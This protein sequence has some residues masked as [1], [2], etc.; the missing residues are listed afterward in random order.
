MTELKFGRYE[1][2]AEIGQGAM[3]KVY[4][5]LDP[6]TDR[7]VAIKTLKDDIVA[8]DKTG[9]YV[10]RFQREARAAGGLSHPNIIKVY[11]VGENYYVMEYL[12]GK[13]LLTLL[14]EKGTFMLDETLSIVAPIA[15]ALA[16]AHERGVYHRDIKPANIMVFPDG[17][18]IITDFGLAHLE[19]SVMTTAGQFLGSPSYMSP[20][21]VIGNELT[22][23]ADLYSLA[24]VTYEM[25]TGDKPFPG[26]NITTVVYKIV[27][28]PPV[29][30]HELN[31]R[32]PSEYEHIFAKALAKEPEQRFADF[33][34]FVSALNLEQFDR[35][36]LGVTEDEPTLVQLDEDQETVELPI[37]AAESRS[38]VT[39]RKPKRRALMMMSQQQKLI[40]AGAAVVLAAFIGLSVLFAPDPLAEGVVIETDPVEAN[41]FLDGE[42]LGISPIELPP[43]AF[44]EHDVRVEKEG[45]LPFEERFELIAGNAI[46]P[47]V[48]ALQSARISL[49]LESVPAGA[50]VTID[51]ESSGQTPLEDV[52]LEPGQ[53]EIQVSRRGYNSWRRVL[54]ARAGESVNLVARLRAR[55]V[56]TAK[57]ASAASS[58]PAASVE[59]AAPA[60]PA[61]PARIVELGPDDTPAKH[62]S[63]KAP[64]YPPMARKL[65]QQGRVTIEFVLTEEG[66]PTELVVVESAGAIL[67]KA[68]LDALA[69][70]RYEPAM[71]NNEPVRVKMRVRQRFRLG[72]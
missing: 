65:K 48:F 69:K 60:E 43:M 54:V 2:E 9:E 12:E 61:G 8:Q 3:G 11:D 57:K 68:V 41:V 10:K 22:S 53:H 42:L 28:I 70:W 25:L 72:R 52:E 59:P 1:V 21:Q 64:R 29:P 36:E 5:A 46:E 35:L 66:V 24:V 19:S 20:E 49:F 63:G 6:L 44:G 40:A 18:S 47:L 17:R 67:D 27:N 30:P 39:E 51:G 23:R 16:Y 14:H 4:R 62:I 33:S 55:A 26:T 56:R 71:R 58:A 34:E 37:P 45:F 7:K 13:D 15:D 50:A 38:N 31:A 32:L